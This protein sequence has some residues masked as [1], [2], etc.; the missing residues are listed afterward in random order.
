MRIEN[1][2]GNVNIDFSQ[3]LRSRDRPFSNVTRDFWTFW[4]FWQIWQFWAV[5]D[6]SSV[7]I[8]MSL[9]L[10]KTCK[11]RF[12]SWILSEQ[13]HEVVR[14]ASKRVKRLCNAPIN[15]I[16]DSKRVNGVS[17][18]DLAFSCPLVIADIS[19]REI[20]C[21]ENF[22]CNDQVITEKM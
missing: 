10:G 11:T 3:C 19:D 17:Y 2:M 4:H 5:H 7:C 1:V 12:V 6:N 18:A 9:S 20:T 21:V 16:N 8:T 14:L 22:W 13:L 15:S